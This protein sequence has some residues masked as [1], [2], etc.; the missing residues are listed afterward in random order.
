MRKPGV[1]LDDVLELAV[2]DLFVNVRAEQP[3][4]II[5]AVAVHQGL[6]L[7]HEHGVECFAKQATRH[8]GFGEAADPGVDMVIAAARRVEFG[9]AGDV[10]QHE[11]QGLVGCV[12][13]RLERTVGDR[14][15]ERAP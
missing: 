8:V 4:E 2:V 15:V 11:G 13:H 10:V 7:R 1:A 3:V 6:D 14:T 9:I 12:A 5:E